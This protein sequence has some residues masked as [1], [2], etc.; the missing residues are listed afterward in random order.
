MIGRAT[1]TALSAT[2]LKTTDATPSCPAPPVAARRRCS[3]LFLQ[4]ERVELRE[5]HERVELCATKRGGGGAARAACGAA[6]V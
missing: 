5:L 3:A 2:T 6:C 4:A 1:A